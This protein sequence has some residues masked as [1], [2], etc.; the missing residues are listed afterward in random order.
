MRRDDLDIRALV[1]A[2]DVVGL[3]GHA[4]LEDVADAA[5]EVLDEEPVADLHPVAVDRQRGRR[6][7][8]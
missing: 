3:A 8:R 7:G 5:R 1:G 4:V 2:A 6:A